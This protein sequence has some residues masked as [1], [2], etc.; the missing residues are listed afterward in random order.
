M[1]QGCC[2]SIIFLKWLCNSTAHTR[3]SACLC[4]WGG[5]RATLRQ[6]PFI[7]GSK[8]QICDGETFC[9]H[10]TAQKL[11][12]WYEKLKRWKV[13]STNT[14]MPQIVMVTSR[15]M[16]K[17]EKSSHPFSGWLCDICGTSL[18]GGNGRILPGSSNYSLLFIALG[19]WETYQVDWKL[20]RD[21]SRNKGVAVAVSLMAQKERETSWC[22]RRNPPQLVVT[23]F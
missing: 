19:N 17:S 8:Y 9:S 7:F 21:E 5:E 14:L 22:G 20:Q 23:A 12:W 3:G 13:I 2:S 4:V 11:Y 18:A 16:Q 15:R 6:K 10:T 1:L